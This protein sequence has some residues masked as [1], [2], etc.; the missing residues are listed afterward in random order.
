MSINKSVTVRAPAQLTASGQTDLFENAHG[1]SAHFVIDITAV[2][3]TS[4]TVT[5]TVEGFDP[6]SGKYYTIIASTALS[7]LAT[8]TLK[9]GPGQTAAANL[10]V[11]DVMPAKFRVRFTLGGSASPTVTFSVGASLIS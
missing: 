3:G 6:A 7:A 9:V 11:N 5:V 4:P 1:K 8:T 2:S 10:V